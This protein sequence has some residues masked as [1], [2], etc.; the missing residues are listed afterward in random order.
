MLLE[1][2][3]YVNIR[4]ISMNQFNLLRIKFGFT[5]P[6]T[7]NGNTIYVRQTKQFLKDKMKLPSE[8]LYQQYLT[9]NIYYYFRISL[10]KGIEFSSS[11][12]VIDFCKKNNIPIVQ[13]IGHPKYGNGLDTGIYGEEYKEIYILS[14]DLVNSEGDFYKEVVELYDLIEVECTLRIGRKYKKILPIS[15]KDFYKIK[16]RETS[17]F[18][19]QL[20][21]CTHLK[22]VTFLS[23]ND[24]RNNPEFKKIFEKYAKP[25][26]VKKG[27]IYRV[28]SN[29]I[30]ERVEFALENGW[31]QA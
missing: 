9:E 3:E 23:T 30:Y 5:V 29:E 4:T 31:N 26:Y 22:L 1:R 24:R 19:D 6:I 21:R 14:E 11:K 27:S 16:L 20:V 25:L 15:K 28:V 7:L 2:K 10:D 8:D 12:K 13:V 17:E 18:V